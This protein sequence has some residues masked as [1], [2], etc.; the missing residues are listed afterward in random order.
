MLTYCFELAIIY[1]DIKVEF[2]MQGLFIMIKMPMR[3]NMKKTV[4]T[5]SVTNCHASV[6]LSETDK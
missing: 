1:S 3:E 4:K 6:T 2:K 5:G